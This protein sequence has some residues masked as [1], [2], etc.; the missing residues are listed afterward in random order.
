MHAKPVISP[1]PVWMLATT[2]PGDVHLAIYWQLTECVPN[3]P[4]ILPCPLA[5]PGFLPTSRSRVPTL[6]AFKSAAWAYFPGLLLPHHM[7]PNHKQVQGVF[8]SKYSYAM[9]LFLTASTA[10]VL[11]KPASHWRKSPVNKPGVV[12]IPPLHPCTAVTLVFSLV[13]SLQ[14][15]PVPLGLC[16]CYSLHLQAFLLCVLSPPAPPLRESAPKHPV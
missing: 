9:R 13:L 8:S 14:K 12:C 7:H 1:G 15:T 3:R 6:S 11:A 5:P 16:V 10:T 4:L 2:S